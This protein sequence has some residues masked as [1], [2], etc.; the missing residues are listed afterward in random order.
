MEELL[1]D[2]ASCLQRCRN[3]HIHWGKMAAQNSPYLRHEPTLPPTRWKVPKWEISER[4]IGFPDDLSRRK[5]EQANSMN[6]LEVKKKS[7]LLY[8]RFYIE[9]SAQACVWLR[10]WHDGKEMGGAIKYC[11][12]LRCPCGVQWFDIERRIYRCVLTCFMFK[13]VGCVDGNWKDC[14][15][16]LYRRFDEICRCWL[17][18]VDGIDSTWLKPNGWI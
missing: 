6:W 5:I 17:L 10:V 12:V 15:G 1:V 8:K 14:K 16:N 11:T 4:P 2:E 13:N 9:G 18:N 3:G 7:K